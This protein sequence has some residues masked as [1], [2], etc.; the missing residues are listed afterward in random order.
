MRTMITAAC[1][2]ALSGCASI[3]SPLDDGYRVGDLSR[4]VYGGT[5]HL[6]SLRDA[7]CDAADDTARNAL[8]L[9]IRAIEPGY[10]VEGVCMSLPGAGR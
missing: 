8:L 4:T 7:Y 2:A 5:A 1:L 10:P 3:E 9:G 6:M